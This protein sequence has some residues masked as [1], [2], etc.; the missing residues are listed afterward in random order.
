VTDIQ[1]V[2]DDENL[3]YYQFVSKILDVEPYNTQ[4]IHI[5]KIAKAYFCMGKIS[6]E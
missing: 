3:E 4:Q 6:F 2:P 1:E 5:N